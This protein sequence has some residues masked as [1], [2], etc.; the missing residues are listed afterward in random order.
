[1]SN[2][3][4]SQQVFSAL[5]A[6]GASGMTSQQIAQAT[7]LSHGKVSGAL[8]HAHQSGE[9]L[10]LPEKRGR[11]RVYV[12][13]DQATSAQRAVA[14]QPRQ[15]YTDEYRFV[16]QDGTEHVTTSLAEALAWQVAGA[17]AVTVEVRR[18][19]EWAPLP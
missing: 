18:V 9:A 2:P 3:T 16:A 17:G 14:V 1:M 19:S 13:A 11:Y 7:G 5:S 12:A 4:T 15:R 10:L 6:A 8:S